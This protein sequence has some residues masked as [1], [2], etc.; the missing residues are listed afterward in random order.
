MVGDSDT[1]N[2]FVE[3]REHP[4]AVVKIEIEFKTD[5][6]TEEY[7]YFLHVNGGTGVK[8]NL[9]DLEDLPGGKKMFTQ[10]NLVID[11]IYKLKVTAEDGTTIGY[12]TI[13]VTP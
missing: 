10:R 3:R 4:R 11:S 8:L 9:E 1:N 5:F 12:Y 2:Q 13:I 7:S 6:G